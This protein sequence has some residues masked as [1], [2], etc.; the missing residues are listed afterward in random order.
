MP[1][2]RRP[3]NSVELKASRKI[4]GSFALLLIGAAVAT[5]SFDSPVAQALFSARA[6]VTAAGTPVKDTGIANP[7]STTIGMKTFSG[8]PG[9]AQNLT[10]WVLGVGT[11]AYRIDGFSVPTGLF[12]NPI[13]FGATAA[14]PGDGVFETWTGKTTFIAKPAGALFKIISSDPATGPPPAKYAPT[15]NASASYF[16]G[17]IPGQ[18]KYIQL[19]AIAGMNKAAPAGTQSGSYNMD[20][21]PIVAV[22]GADDSN[23]FD[24][25]SYSPT[26]GGPVINGA[27]DSGNPTYIPTELSVDAPGEVAVMNFFADDSNDPTLQTTAS[28]PI[29]DL[30]LKLDSTSGT[31]VL[32]AAF[33]YDSTRLSLSG[34]LTGSQILA[35]LLADTTDVTYTNDG[36]SA[37]LD[38]N[39]AF[40]LF[41]GT[42]TASLNGASQDP[43]SDTD[44]DFGFGTDA[45]VVMV[46]EPSTFTLFAAAGVMLMR[47]KR[48]P[49]A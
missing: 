9:G 48:A 32:S 20:P 43:E 3:L 23:N 39:N 30:T 12:T 19:G 1:C 14:N 4:Q 22:S 25:Y 6:G 38:I 15:D 46:P 16:P 21:Y 11:A 41:T 37:A 36:T 33:T 42:Y 10:R 13:V 29:W 40:P 34:D 24:T 17:G 8:V 35:N 49:T 7:L 47:R 44:I 45:A 2:A 26:I 31:P 18:S 27:D 5:L 28:D